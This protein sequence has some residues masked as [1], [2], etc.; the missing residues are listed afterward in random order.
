MVGSPQEVRW[1]LWYISSICGKEKKKQRSFNTIE[2]IQYSNLKIVW[3]KCNTI[4]YT[5]GVKYDKE[6][7]KILETATQKCFLKIFLLF[8]FH[9]NSNLFDNIDIGHPAAAGASRHCRAQAHPASDTDYFFFTPGKYRTQWFMRLP[10][11]CMEIWSGTK[12][13]L[14]TSVRGVAGPTGARRNSLNDNLCQLHFL[15][16]TNYPYQQSY[17][18]RTG[19]VGAMEFRM[20]WI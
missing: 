9:K 18:N 12:R 15:R 20:R 8:F 2:K 13:S 5:K 3:K 17:V 7:R 6:N 11:R 16:D 1:I 14:T 10:G 19:L 4:K